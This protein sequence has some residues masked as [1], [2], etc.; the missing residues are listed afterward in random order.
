MKD[1]IPDVLDTGT[2]WK[3]DFY[4]SWSLTQTGELRQSERLENNWPIEEIYFIIA[5]KSVFVC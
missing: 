4:L 3:A 2:Y 5:H 1:D